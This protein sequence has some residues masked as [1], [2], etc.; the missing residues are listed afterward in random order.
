MPIAP[1]NFSVL[2]E[3]SR[4]RVHIVSLG[5]PKN[6][7]DSELMIGQLQGNGYTL[8]D[9]PGDAD[10][11]VVNT[12]AFIESAKEESIET[13]LEMAEYKQSGSAERLVVTGCMAQRY[14]TELQAEMPEVDTFLGTNEFKRITSAAA[15]VLPDRSYVTYGSALYTSDE[16]RVN[17]VRA[18]SAYLKIAEGCN[19]TCSFCII[20]KIRGKQVSRP[21]DDLIAEARILGASGVKEI[22]LI[23][24]DLTS[25]GV[26]I[27]QKGG[28]EE[29]LVQLEDV[30]GIEWVRLHYAYPWG[31]TDR[32]LDIVRQSNKVLPYV[33][34]PLQHISDNI[35]KAMR[36]N[37]R[38]EAQRDLLARLREVPDM[39]IR[40]VFITGFPGETD[41]DFDDLCDWMQDVK[42]D[43][44][45]V[46]AYS[47]E[48][49]TTAFDMPNQVPLAIAEQR[50]D[51]LME[52]QQ[53]ISRKKNEDLIGRRLKVLVD[54]VSEE[55]ELVFEG[56]HYGQALDI[57]GVVYL[58][59]E[60]GAP[61]VTPGEFVEV[62][63]DD[64]T[65]YDLVGVVR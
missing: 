11:L 55:H 20:P 24:Q 53:A 41:A 51:H 4:K 60:D 1:D 27:G 56:R 32:L 59:F 62:E 42:F 14:A 28:L 8:V 44:V 50:R 35:L 33:D 30:K 12:C 13:I 37:V 29:L 52:L 58:S 57:D 17:T 21:L 39:V 23:A 46:F 7:V 16:A 10:V 3:L 34:M 15:G 45:G 48:E 26:D 6:R 5:C 49:N 61:M 54:G 43:R 63:I 65:E 31:F 25:Y 40:T 47:R 2:N 9:E 19:R 36:R 18:G 38:R 64:A 22:S